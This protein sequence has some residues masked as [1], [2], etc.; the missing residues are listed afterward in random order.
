MMRPT[1][2]F[3]YVGRSGQ[4]WAVQRVTSRKRSRH[5]RDA[6]LHFPRGMRRHVD[7][8]IKSRQK[9]PATHLVSAAGK[10]SR[11]VLLASGASTGSGQHLRFGR[12]RQQRC[13]GA[14]GYREEA[15]NVS[16]K[17]GEGKVSWL[18]L[19]ARVVRC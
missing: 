3:G 19:D 2:Q 6:T 13:F 15:P 18:M 14:S 7:S 16:G 4:P 12:A 5:R 9:E 17:A 1:W 11:L 10:V 8:H